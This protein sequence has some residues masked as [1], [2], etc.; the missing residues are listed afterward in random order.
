MNL[1]KSKENSKDLYKNANEIKKIVNDLRNVHLTKN[2]QILKQEDKDKLV[3]YLDKVDKTNNDYKTLQYLSRTLKDI[4]NELSKSKEI[5]KILQESNSALELRN[6]KLKEENNKLKTRNSSLE[7]ELKNLKEIFEIFKNKLERLYHFFVDKMWENKEKQDKYYG[8]AYEL[9]GKSILDD[10]QMNG[11]LEIKQR[12]AEI[13][14]ES[15]S[16]DD[17]FEL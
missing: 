14:N 15:K 4:S 9:Y 3:E 13:D 17:D 8:V 7:N 6:T 5:I 10:K 12:S 1:E 16:R 2:S 11:I